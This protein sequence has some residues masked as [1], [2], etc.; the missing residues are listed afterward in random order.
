MKTTQAHRSDKIKTNLCFSVIKNKR[1]V[2]LVT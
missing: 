1:W 2:C